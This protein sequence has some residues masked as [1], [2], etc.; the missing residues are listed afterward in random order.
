[1]LIF[2]TTITTIIAIAIIPTIPTIG[3]LKVI[4]NLFAAAIMI[5]LITLAAAIIITLSL[6]W[7]LPI[8]N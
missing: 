7:F 1:M 5:A 8:F 2:I 4:I 6:L 3:S